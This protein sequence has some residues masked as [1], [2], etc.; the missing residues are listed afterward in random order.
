[1]WATGQK[2]IDERIS[3][4]PSSA[5]DVPGNN[6]HG[7]YSTFSHLV[8]RATVEPYVLW[9]LTPPGQAGA[10]PELVT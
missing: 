10:P 9:R 5:I 1:M 4:G 6:L 8:P 2:T 7:I 3:Q